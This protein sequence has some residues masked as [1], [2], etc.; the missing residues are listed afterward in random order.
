MKPIVAISLGDP[1]GIGPEI[2]VKALLED[3]V[4][5]KVNHILIGDVRILQKALDLLG[6]DDLSIHAVKDVDNAILEAKVLNIIDTPIDIESVREIK[7]GE[8]KPIY[9]KAAVLAV[10]KAAQLC[11]SKKVNA[12]ASAPLNKDAMRKAGY[13]YEGQT[14]MLAELA[15]VK[16]FGMVLMAENV[17]AYMLTTHMS[18]RDACDAVTKEKVLNAITLVDES[19]KL[20]GYKKPRIA[21]AGLNPHSGENGLFGREEID[22]MVPAIEEAKRTNIKV[23]GPVPADT[24]YLKVKDGIFDVVIGMSHDQVNIPLKII[25]FGDIVTLVLG[26]PFIRTSVGHGTAFDIAGKNIADHN[27]MKKAIIKAG[28]LSKKG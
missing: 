28:E 17:M 10:K 9:G 4:K 7:Y 8:V 25:G 14:Q 12:T 2:T 20:L 5:S 24:A 21:V 27:N 3:E 11:L 26:L 22:E 23:T 1:V 19:L 6:I 15:D 13:H 16:R 18:L